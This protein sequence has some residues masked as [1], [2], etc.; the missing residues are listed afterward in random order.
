M[1]APDSPNY[2]AIDN[3][4]RFIRFSG[5]GFA[6]GAIWFK[7]TRNIGGQREFCSEAEGC[8]FNRGI[9]AFFTLEY[10]GTGDGLVFAL[11]NGSGGNN[12]PSSIGG[13]RERSEMLGYSGDSRLDIAGTTFAD[14]SGPRGLFPPKIGLEFDTKVNYHGDFES[15]A[16]NYCS[17]ASNLVA[18]TRNDPG[19]TSST[20]VQD[21]NSKDAVQYVFWGN[22]SLTAACRANNPSYDDNRHNA[23]GLSTD[24]SL[25]A[26]LN[27][28]SSPAIGPDGIVYVGSANNLMSA[29]DP[30]NPTAWKWRY[31]TSGAAPGSPV[32]AGSGS[33]Y[34]IYF[35]ALNSNFYAI[36]PQGTN[37]AG[38][39]FLTDPAAELTTKPV[40]GGDGTIYF[41]AIDVLGSGFIDGYVYAIRPSGNL[42]GRRAR[43]PQAY[44]G[45]FSDG[46][47][48][49][50]RRVN[51]LRR[52][53]RYPHG[54][55]P[56][57]ERRDSA[58]GPADSGDRFS[59]QRVRFRRR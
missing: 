25:S 21:P 56:A 8:Q 46:A 3:T 35:G 52:C 50:A 45:L 51:A 47:R 30:K 1:V 18:S 7:D 34:T 49:F 28:A 38:F 32:I 14:T 10:A 9:R 17:S 59:R 29:V 27:I 41:S 16:K 40:V 20:P 42:G 55:R 22:S 13:D 26:G 4:D 6:L 58:L 31:S 36:T 48:A 57:H 44:P 11:I 5:P 33:N 53:R 37:K 24:W 15:A 39:P 23:E 54:V 12:D 43:K 19:S 2:I